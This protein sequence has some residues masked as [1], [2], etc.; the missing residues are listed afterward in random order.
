MAELI[1]EKA[2][3]WTRCSNCKKI[4]P[5]ELFRY[6]DDCEY[7]PKFNFCPNCGEHIDKKAIDESKVID[8][9]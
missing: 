8:N 1:Y 2:F 5:E 9:A 3:R 4:Y 7:L 6:F